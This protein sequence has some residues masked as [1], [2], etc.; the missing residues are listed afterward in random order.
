MT[1]HRVEFRGEAVVKAREGQTILDAALLNGIDLPHDCRSGRCGSCRVTLLEGG[2]DG[3]GIDHGPSVLACQ[4]RITGAVTIEIEPVPPLDTAWGVVRA[5]T[6]L[7]CGVVEVAVAPSR[8]IACLPGQ[9]LSFRFRGFPTRRYSPTWSLSGET[10]PGVIYLHVRRV[11]D[12]IVSQ[13]FGD[14]IVSGHRVRIR[15]PFGSSFFRPNRPGRLVLV[16]AG[17]G[18]APIWAIAQA[19][20]T[21]DPNRNMVV[22]VGARSMAHLYMA[23]ALE[24]LAR[25][26]NVAI[27]AFLGRHEAGTPD[28]LVG[29]A[30]DRLPPLWNDDTIFACGSP[31]TVEEVR[32]FCAEAGVACHTD[33]F[34][35]P[36]PQI[37]RQAGLADTDVDGLVARLAPM[38][39]DRKL[40]VLVCATQ[41]DASPEV[42]GALAAALGPSAVV[43]VGAGVKPTGDQALWHMLQVPAA[44]SGRSGSSRD[45]TAEWPS[46]VAAEIDRLCRDN[47]ILIIS[48]PPLERSH[49]A[50]I[51]AAIADVTVLLTSDPLADRVAVRGLGIQGSGE[52]IEV[53]MGTLWSAAA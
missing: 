29:T 23:P 8:P 17:T 34:A 39:R 9:Y 26:P 14:T 50:W 40:C 27:R 46:R 12:G 20:L 24:R 47:D 2:T 45:G 42:S 10:E 35:S 15:G 38:A 4:A 22:I 36:G 43:A 51:F 48:T 3:G 5:V 16:G 32:S 33:S 52:V 19:A 18:F 13:A 1:T 53:T 25:S 37:R 44:L 41:G 21:E 49:L 7:G 31:E 6:E 30:V 28:A 11:R